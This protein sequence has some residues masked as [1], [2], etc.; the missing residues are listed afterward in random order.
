MERETPTYDELVKENA[1]L[2]ARVAEL[3]KYINY[4]ENKTT[5]ENQPYASYFSNSSNTFDLNDLKSHATLSKEQIERYS[6]QL[7]IPEIGVKGTIKN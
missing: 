7:L 6:R 4:N 2:K 5:S 1:K 3:E